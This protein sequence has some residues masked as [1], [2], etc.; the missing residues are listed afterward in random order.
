MVN[1]LINPMTG[2]PARFGNQN[3]QGLEIHANAVFIK[4][5]L[6]K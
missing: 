3:H 4:R 1:D 5:K 6:G 2:T